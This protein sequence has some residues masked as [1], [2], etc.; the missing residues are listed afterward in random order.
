MTKVEELKEEFERVR[1][2][3]RQIYCVKGSEFCRPELEM[4]F[5]LLAKTP[6]LIEAVREE[7]RGRVIKLIIKE[8]PDSCFM[9]NTNHDESTMFSFLKLKTEKQP[10]ELENLMMDNIED[11]LI[12]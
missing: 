11:L 12:D 2:A 8:I 7:E 6:E 10:P 4:V 3:V 5:N 1:I 9:P